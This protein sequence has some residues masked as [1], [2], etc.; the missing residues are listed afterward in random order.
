VWENA[1]FL[2]KQQ[3]LRPLIV[4]RSWSDAGRAEAKF[5]RDSCGDGRP[6]DKLRVNADLPSAQ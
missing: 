4:A 5:E 2:A 1:G 6:L 3:F